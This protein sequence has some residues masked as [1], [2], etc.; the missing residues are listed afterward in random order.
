M[1]EPTWLEEHILWPMS[2]T[3]WVVASK[4]YWFAVDAWEWIKR[5]KGCQ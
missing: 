4:V 1:K 2:R 5:K 3:W